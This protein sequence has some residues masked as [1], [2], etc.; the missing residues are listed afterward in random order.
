MERK[1]RKKPVKVQQQRE[2]PEIRKI[3]GGAHCFITAEMDSELISNMVDKAELV[4]DEGTNHWSCIDF[5]NLKT[6]TLCLN[7]S[8]ACHAKQ[9]QSLSCSKT[10]KLGSAKNGHQ[11]ESGL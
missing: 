5:F 1:M 10:R 2:Q 11:D 9:L 8:R 4:D 3:L 6:T 7:N